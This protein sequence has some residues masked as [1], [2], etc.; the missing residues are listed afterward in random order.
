LTL[1]AALTDAFSLGVNVQ[2]DDVPLQ[3]PDQPA[4]VLFELGFATSVSATP[5]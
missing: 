3:P 4:K 1:K 5:G 2:V